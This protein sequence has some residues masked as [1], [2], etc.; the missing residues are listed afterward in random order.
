MCKIF[1]LFE[2]L[3]GMQKLYKE[4]VIKLTCHLYPVVMSAHTTLMK[5]YLYI[6]NKLNTIP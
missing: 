3:Q 5:C 6:T 2:Y 1:L 4:K